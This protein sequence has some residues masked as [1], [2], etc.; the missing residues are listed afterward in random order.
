[1]KNARPEPEIFVELASL[2]LSPGYIH[3]IAYICWRDNFITYAKEM[4]PEDMA[5]SYAPG[6]LIRTEISTLI[7]LMVKGE[8]DYTVPKPTTLQRYLDK[9]KELL[10]ELHWSMMAPMMAS[11]KSSSAGPALRPF[12]QGAVLREPIFYGGESAYS[13]QYRD[14][15]RDRYARDDS[16]LEANKGFTASEAHAAVS[17]ISRIQNKR[18]VSTLEAF[19]KAQSS[20]WTFLPGFTFSVSDVAKVAHL[21]SSHAAAILKAFSLD[22]TE[23]NDA[24]VS[25]S[26][27][28]ITN[29]LPIIETPDGRYILLQAYSIVE[30]LYD[31]P[32]YWMIADEKYRQTAMKH[33]GEFTE[34]LSA[35][36]LQSVFG[37][38]SVYSNV[39]IIGPKREKLGEIDVLVSFGNR[40]IILQAKSKKMTLEARRGNDLQ[41]RDDFKKAVQDAYDQGFKCAENLK[42]GTGTLVGSDGA[43][44]ALPI[45][46]EEIYILCVVSDHYPA[47]TVQA[48]EFLKWQA[49]DG[50]YPPLVTDVFLLDVLAE[51][52]NSPLRLLSYVDRRVGYTD[53]LTSI[54]ELTI[55]GHH[56]SRNL[57][58]DEE[59]D[60]VMISDDVAID[61]DT[62]MC[63]RREGVDGNP[64]PR[65]IL[66]RVGQTA[67]GKLLGMIEAQTDPAL[68]D[69]GF[70]L[71]TLSEDTINDV[72]AGI[73]RITHQARDDGKSHDVTVG[74]D[75]AGTGLTIHS[76][77]DSNSDA[78]RRLLNHC[79]LRKYAHKADN[80]FGLC[81]RPSDG[82]PRFGIYLKS[83]WQQDDTL[84]AATA[85]METK[86]NT[87]LGQVR[88]KSETKR[89]NR[90]SSFRRKLLLE[91]SPLAITASSKS[92]LD[93][94]PDRVE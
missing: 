14:F 10:E 45:R 18:L 62:A 23:M 51:M 15:A 35:S 47:L 64:T 86:G 38:V 93:L 82:T 72:S 88:V 71:L 24:F 19:R 59:Y 65:G 73:S 61:L 3:A 48:R 70:M 39:D 69:L 90:I 31:S 79:V 55:L 63:V 27:F 25:L 2:C 41:I 78:A 80:W 92:P 84:D 77:V 30:S 12:G 17:A 40:A 7:G 94:A 67:V 21:D 22:K 60:L 85:G 8:I 49:V 76:N 68:I 20:S 58:L 81:L 36:R 5:K 26:D 53:K 11:F 16:W 33:R 9:T 91:G 6:R 75:D 66:T 34:R 57:W 74:F 42:A 37:T 1:M 52:L 46:P 89:G 32:F 4:T 44:I 87:D 50:I 83:K 54:N 56:L 13:F 28:N 29:A 43:E